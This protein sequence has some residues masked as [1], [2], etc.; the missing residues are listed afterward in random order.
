MTPA[1]VLTNLIALTLLG[2]ACVHSASD[3][4]ASKQ[5]GHIVVGF[6][7]L[8]AV[9]QSHSWVWRK[10]APWAYLSALGLLALV[11]LPGVGQSANGS[12][13]WLSMGP[14][15]ALQP[16]ELAKMGLI[17][18]LARL[19]SPL[20]REGQEYRPSGLGR[21]VT[22]GLLTGLPFVLI[23]KQPDLG[24]ALVLAAIFFL[25]SFL[26]GVNVL[27]LGS[28]VVAGAAVLP[29]VLKEYQRNRLLIFLHPETDPQGLGYHILQSK[30]TIGSGQIYG[31]GLLGGAMTQHGFVPENWTDFVFTVVGEELGFLGA[32]GV[33]LLGLA[34]LG[35]LAVMTARSEDRFASL[36][37]AGV[38]A[39][40]GFQWLVNLSMT[41]GLAPVVGIPL[42]FFSYG[43]SAMLVNL[44]G[45][46]IVLASGQVVK[47]GFSSKKESR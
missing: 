13:R 11:M 23:A 24:T 42:P 17:L 40:L 30:L 10:S 22:A 25:V 43:G 26:A 20:P 37:S 47:T 6:F 2:L 39:M 29:H 41:V 8:R 18:A 34:L 15:G 1:T 5:A 28:V 9:W 27:A 38:L 16:S 19:Y 31:Q 33:L 46:G 44:A 36:A 7:L 4:V 35:Q 32:L 21:F 12:Q 14:L 45:I 3:A